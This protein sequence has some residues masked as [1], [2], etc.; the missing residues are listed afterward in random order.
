M[1]TP[2]FKIELLPD[3]NQQSNSDQ[4]EDLTSLFDARLISMIITDNRGFESDTIEMQLNDAD[5]KLKLPKRKAKL[6]VTLGWSQIQATNKDSDDNI[7]GPNI[8]NVFLIDEVEHSGTPDL[9]T[10]RGRSAQNTEELEEKKEQSYENITLGDLIAIIAKRNNL[11]YRFD[12]DIGASQIFHMD[13]TQESDISF[14]TRMV[15][16]AGGVVTVKNDIMLVFKKGKGLT[17]GGKIIPPAIIKRE[18]G[19]KHRFFTS[20]RTGYTGVQTYWYDYANPTKNPHK[21]IYKSQ[22]DKSQIVL[23]GKNEKIKIIRYVY[24]NKQSAEKAAESELNKIKQGTA[25]FTIELAKGRPDLFTEMPVIVEGFKTEI[26]STNWTIIQCVHTLN[27]S[28]GFKTT[29]HLE[30]KL[31]DEIYYNEN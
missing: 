24:A 20:E 7:I 23:N 2:K 15:D 11:A 22:I 31:K 27:R 26:D 13:Q 14:L 8:K 21:I 28:A 12:K 18:S 5:G 6:A 9:M 10:I 30:I 16:E 19:D 1:A 4:R 29:V 3:N 25:Q 17:V